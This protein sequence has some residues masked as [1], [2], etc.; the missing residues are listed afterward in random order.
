MKYF[1]VILAALLPLFYLLPLQAQQRGKGT[2]YSSRLTG[3]RMSDGSRYHR[4]SMVCAHRTHPFGTLLKVT[5]VRNGREVIVR[6]ADRGPFGRGKIIDLSYKAA[7][8]LGILSQGVA[9]VEVEVYRPAPRVPMRA[10][11]TVEIPEIDFEVTET[12]Y[13]FTKGWS[14]KQEKK[15]AIPRRHVQRRHVATPQHKSQPKKASVWS[16]IFKFGK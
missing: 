4:D 3:R 14:N 13:D 11:Q 12:G 9:M 15:P 1:K 8:D 2:Y 10:E 6:V 16:N 7:K 5:N